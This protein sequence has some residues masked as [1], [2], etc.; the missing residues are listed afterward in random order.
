M[1]VDPKPDEATLCAVWGVKVA[2]VLLGASD[3]CSADWG[4]SDDVGAGADV[5]EAGAGSPLP[6]GPALPGL[7]VSPTAV[8]DRLHISVSA[9]F[10]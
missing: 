1:L 10:G 2:L 7:S 8:L 5:N 9:G 3:V 4:A 6:M